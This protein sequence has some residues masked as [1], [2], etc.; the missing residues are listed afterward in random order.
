MH[1]DSGS[2][3]M[4][5]GTAAKLLNSLSLRLSRHSLS[6]LRFTMLSGRRLEIFQLFTRQ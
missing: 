5:A 6:S 1:V 4:G 2:L 3:T